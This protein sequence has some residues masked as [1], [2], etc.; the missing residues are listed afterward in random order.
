LGLAD[1]LLSLPHRGV[2]GLS[3]SPALLD[4]GLGPGQPPLSLV[5]LPLRIAKILLGRSRGRTCF[6]ELPTRGLEPLALLLLLPFPPAR[7]G[8]L[9]GTSGALRFSL[10][11][12]GE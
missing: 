2:G 1:V 9:L 11:K 12:R 3:G 4:L 5:G 7:T 10:G 8:G 6:A